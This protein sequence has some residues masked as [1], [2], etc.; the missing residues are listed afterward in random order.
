M[1]TKS[2]RKLR[3]SALKT[4]ILN[5]DTEKDC[6]LYGY[7][8]EGIVFDNGLG[9]IDLS[10]LIPQN[11]MVDNVVAILNDANTIVLNS[12]KIIG[13]NTVQLK[14]KKFDGTGYNGNNAGII[15][16]FFICRK[17]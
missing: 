11:Y 14:C 7:T 12:A 6:I 10:K 16:C 2:N 3:N 15:R 4:K 1:E 13:E 17:I 5:D 8:C 9:S